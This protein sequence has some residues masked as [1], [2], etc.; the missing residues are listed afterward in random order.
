MTSSC[1]ADAPP[2]RNLMSAPPLSATAIDVLRRPNPAVM[3]VLMPDGHPMSVAT[4]YLLEDDGR[5]LVNLDGNRARLDWMRR[6]GRV[7]LTVL[8]GSA[9]YTHVSLRGHVSEWRDD[10]ELVDIDR[11]STHYLGHSY[12]NRERPR[13][14]AFIEVEHWHGWGDAAGRP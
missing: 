1:Q 9:W 2:E 5:V 3:A 14:S 8:D 13:V 11:L 7:S 12:P 10:T 4:W 6:D